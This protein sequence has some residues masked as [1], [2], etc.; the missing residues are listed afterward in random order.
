MHRITLATR[1]L[2]LRPGAAAAEPACI[3]GQSIAA[4]CAGAPRFQ[5]RSA[6]GTDRSAWRI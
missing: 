2:V 3:G 6:A 5:L 4:G 1:L